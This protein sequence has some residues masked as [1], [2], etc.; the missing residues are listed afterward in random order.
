MAAL[1]GTLSFPEVHKVAL[2]IPQDLDLDVPWPGE[3]FLQI[4][5]GV[6]KAGEGLSVS[7]VVQGAKL[8]LLLR[9]GACPYPL[10]RRWP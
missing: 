5:G 4:E 2:L 10:L 7:T 8:L 1:D 9:P 3:V 6:A